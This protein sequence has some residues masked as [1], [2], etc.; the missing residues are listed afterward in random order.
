MLPEALLLPVEFIIFFRIGRVLEYL[1][2]LLFYL[3]W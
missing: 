3:V 2:G 1:K